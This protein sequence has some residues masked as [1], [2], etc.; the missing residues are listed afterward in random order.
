MLSGAYLPINYFV[1]TKDLSGIII[2]MKKLIIAFVSLL[3]FTLL[4]SV[5]SAEIFNTDLRLGTTHAEVRT[6]QQFLN[7]D[8]R[9]KLAEE[10]A[11]SPG[12]ETE[13]FGAK[14][15][16]AVK[17]F[18]F[19]YKSEIL[20][21]LNLDQGTGYVGSLTRR[22]LN[23]VA[24]VIGF[25]PSATTLNLSQ[26]GT[27]TSGYDYS[28]QYQSLPLA[29]VPSTAGSGETVTYVTNNVTN[30]Y[31][32]TSSDST[33]STSGSTAYDPYDYSYPT[34]SSYAPQTSTS[35]PP[36]LEPKKEE[37]KTTGGMSG[38][39][40]GGGSTGGG[41]SPAGSDK[42]DDKKDGGIEGFIKQLLAML[43]QRQLMPGQAF[44][45]Y[46][47]NYD[48]LNPNG[49]FNG[50]GYPNDNQSAEC[51][52]IPNMKFPN[53]EWQAYALQQVRASGLSGMRPADADKFFPGE[54]VTDEG[55]V[56]IL[57]FLAKKESNFNPSDTFYETS[58]GYNSVGLLSLSAVDPEARASGYSEEDLKNPYKNIELGA[59]ILART[60]RNDGVIVGRDASGKW[61]GAASYWSTIR[62]CLNNAPAVANVNSCVDQNTPLPDVA[63]LANPSKLA[64]HY[65][66]VVPQRCNC[67]EAVPLD[68]R[69]DFRIK[70]QC[71]VALFSAQASR[72][73][74]W[75][76]LNTTKTG[77]RSLTLWLAP[78]ASESYVYNQVTNPPR[79]VPGDTSDTGVS[80]TLRLRFR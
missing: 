34:A 35:T 25:A 40:G 61:K 66:E 23:A 53:P 71:N 11:G 46:D 12:L 62:G 2:T 51:R 50:Q 29:Q 28:Y 9:T 77:V 63:T 13:Y 45:T 58:L 26:S 55:W 7:L 57:A 44:P 17:R 80:Y 79:F 31:D 67:L 47:S 32:A 5:A 15:D 42:Q 21:P 22:V 54:Q 14:T 27:Q 20:T 33:T 60:I 39:G 43:I 19:L 3:S 78:T 38:G 52:N 69:V 30:V 4:A 59:R 1:V 64:S 24:G 10:G 16:N 75:I 73:S 36:K 37:P 6:L 70:P 72:V 41:S 56:S 49:Q 76:R 68:E 48:P 8:N 74:E 65:E 18:Q